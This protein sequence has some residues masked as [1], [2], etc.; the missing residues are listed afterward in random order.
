MVRSIVQRDGHKSNGGN[1]NSPAGEHTQ[2]NQVFTTLVVEGKLPFEEFLAEFF[3]TEGHFILRAENAAEALAMTREHWPDLIL[4]TREM[5][6]TN[7]LKLLP[8][9][10]QEHPSAAVIMMATAPSVVDAVEA[11]KLG[12]V[13][14][15][16][17]PLNREKL[18]HAIEQQKKL[19]KVMLA[20]EQ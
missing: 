18:K 16:E 11:M 12:A 19:Y 20:T 4:M 7:G 1:G 17:R 14:Y 15:L 5:D 13:D 9:L 8:E 2:R 3:K 10:L 6:G